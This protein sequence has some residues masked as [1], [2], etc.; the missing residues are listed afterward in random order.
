[1]SVKSTAVQF[2]NAFQTLQRA[3]KIR[4]NI[5]QLAKL[6]IEELVLKL[7]ELG[8]LDVIENYEPKEVDDDDIDEDDEDDDDDEDDEDDD[9]NIDEDEDYSGEEEYAQWHKERNKQNKRKAS[10]K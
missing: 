10:K 8:I 3:K 1:M 9:D 2:E 7:N 4:R 5:K 6:D